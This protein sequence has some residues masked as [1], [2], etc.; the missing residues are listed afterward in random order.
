MAR[1]DTARSRRMPFGAAGQQGPMEHPHSQ[2]EEGLERS[3][4]ELEE[5]L[6][7]LDEHIE[8]SE[9][10]LEG[11]RDDAGQPVDD[12]AGDWEDKSAGA[13]QGG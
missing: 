5:R 1:E 6:E 11:R 7:Q 8:E 13:Q 3:G 2:A 10:K 4:D 9:Q 12:V